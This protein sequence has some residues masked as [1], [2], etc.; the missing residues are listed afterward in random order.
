MIIE[1]PVSRAIHRANRTELQYNN[2]YL[3]YV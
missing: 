1:I 2:T 3:I